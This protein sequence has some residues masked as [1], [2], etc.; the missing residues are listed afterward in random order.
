MNLTVVKG[1][2]T[3]KVRP[4]VDDEGNPILIATSNEFKSFL[5]GNTHEDLVKRMTD[6]VE[7]LLGYFIKRGRVGV[8]ENMGFE[9]HRY[10]VPATGSPPPADLEFGPV[11]EV[12]NILQPVHALA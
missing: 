9:V 1:Q 2:V 6:A 11:N 8:L 7:L 12:T 10:D 3:W 4:S 5:W